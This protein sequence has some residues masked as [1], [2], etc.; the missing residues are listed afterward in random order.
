MTIE[1][2]ALALH[3]EASDQ[4]SMY[5]CDVEG[6]CLCRDEIAAIATALRAARN[7]AL[8]EA[9][10]A[11]RSSRLCTIIED[12]CTTDD[13]PEILCCQEHTCQR[14]IAVSVVLALKET[15]P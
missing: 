7:E 12:C 11:L 4:C 8:E 6:E 14:D 3:K 2:K 5:P 13:I 15:T 1:E 10:E 9:A